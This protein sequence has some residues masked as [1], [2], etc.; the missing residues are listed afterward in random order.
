METFTSGTDDVMAARGSERGNPCGE[1]ARNRSQNRPLTATRAP[2][3]VH[4]QVPREKQEKILYRRRMQQAACCRENPVAGSTTGMVSSQFSYALP[5][6]KAIMPHGLAL[7][8][9][10]LTV[11]GS[12]QH[13]Q[14]VR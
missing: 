4:Q 3:L 5:N 10:L 12:Q 11:G 13:A 8:L 2:K 1:H 7:L 6:H 14:H 9:P